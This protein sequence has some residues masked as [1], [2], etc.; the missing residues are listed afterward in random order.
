MGKAF[1]KTCNYKPLQQPARQCLGGPPCI[2]VFITRWS[3]W[4]AYTPLLLRSLAFNR[5]IDFYLISDVPPSYNVSLPANVHFYHVP[6]PEAIERFR[7][8][9]GLKLRTLSVQQRFSGLGQYG[10]TDNA[11]FS[12]AKTNDLKPMLGEVFDE[13]W[14]IPRIDHFPAIIGRAVDAGR[15]R[16]RFTK[17]A[18]E[19]AYIEMHS[20]YCMRAI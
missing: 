8:I 19:H 16:I 20:R 12:A 4:P 7:C 15:V 2:A 10:A 1:S 18:H 13:W 6:L 14:G 9:L 5:F 11:T 17:W 3:N